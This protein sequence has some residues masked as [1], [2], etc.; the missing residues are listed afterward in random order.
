M[1]NNLTRLKRVTNWFEKHV[2]YR[3]LANFGSVVL[4]MMTVLCIATSLKVNS[5]RKEV[6]KLEIKLT[7]VKNKKQKVL[8]IK[9]TDASKLSVPKAKVVCDKADV[10]MSYTNKNPLNV[11]TPGKKQWWKGQIGKDKFG[12]AQFNNWEDGIRAGAI[13][14][15]N[16]AVKH[17]I[18]TIEGIVKRFAE[19][20]QKEYM[21]F[22][23]KRLNIKRDEEFNLLKRLPEVLRAM[24]K[25]ESGMEI[26]EQMFVPY[27]LVVILAD[28]TSIVKEN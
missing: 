16:Y 3:F 23:E 15:K 24:S 6:S 4:I 18:N 10:P 13:V 1:R 12:H 7:E 17:K 22:L 25:F 26:P 14:L 21:S 19:G 5:L 20:N 27:D 28:N 2:S 8:L 9:P 11:K